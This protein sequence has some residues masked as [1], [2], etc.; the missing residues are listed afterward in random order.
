MPA[1]PSSTCPKAKGSYRQTDT[2]LQ[3]LCD[4]QKTAAGG[5]YNEYQKSRTGHAP[6]KSGEAGGS[7]EWRAQRH[8]RAF[9]MRPSHVA[10]VQLRK[11]QSAK[12]FLFLP[13]AA[14]HL[15]P[16]HQ[17]H[18]VALDQQPIAAIEIDQQQRQILHHGSRS[19]CFSIRFSAA[20]LGRVRRSATHQAW[21]SCRKNR[22]P[23][24]I[25]TK[26]LTAPIC[27]ALGTPLAWPEAK[28][29]AGQVR[30]WG[31]EVRVPLGVKQHTRTTG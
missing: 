15:L 9:V 27:R 6:A 10:G 7:R 14:V 4:N 26:P 21:V 30:E 2:A 24:P 17:D 28:K 18:A 8:H 3:T 20:N 16:I 12:H 25:G 22:R 19:F 5:R 31:I 29:V 23:V 11:A 13:L 1:L